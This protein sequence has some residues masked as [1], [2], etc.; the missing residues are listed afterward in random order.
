M[1]NNIWVTTDRFLVDFALQ[2]LTLMVFP[3][4]TAILALFDHSELLVLIRITIVTTIEDNVPVLYPV[5]GIC[6]CLG[7]PTHGFFVP[8]ILESVSLFHPIR[9]EHIDHLGKNSL[10]VFRQNEILIDFPRYSKFFA[11]IL[12]D[13]DA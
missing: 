11:T 6:D 1:P 4:E 12:E 3:S 10:D 7:Y 13:F 8:S 9:H 5:P 2:S